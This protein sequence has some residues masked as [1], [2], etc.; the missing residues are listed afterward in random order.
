MKLIATIMDVGTFYRVVSVLKGEET[1]IFEFGGVR[2][3]EIPILEVFELIS[4]SLKEGKTVLIPKNLT[5]QLTANELIIKD[6]IDEVEAS[7]QSVRMETKQFISNR[8]GGLSMFTF[9]E[10]VI[11]NNQLISKGFSITQENREEKY[12]EIINI[13][14]DDLIA[15][16]EKYLECLDELSEKDFMYNSWKDFSNSLEEINSQDEIKEKLNIFHSALI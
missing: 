7:K 11:L 9:F 5:N 1:S 6:T 8:L 12:L 15:L 16:L 3:Y 14:D 13:G 2:L 10:F 4:K